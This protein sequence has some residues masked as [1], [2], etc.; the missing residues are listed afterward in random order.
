LLK[1]SVAGIGCSLIEQPPPKQK[2]N[3]KT[4]HPKGTTKS[5]IWGAETPE[6]IATKFCMTAVAYKWNGIK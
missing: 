1:N 4:S 6:P 3:K 5:R 2:T